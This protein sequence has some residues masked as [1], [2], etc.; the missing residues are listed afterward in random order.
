MFLGIIA[1]KSIANITTLDYIKGF[2]DSPIPS[3]EVGPERTR[4]IIRFI[5]NLLLQAGSSEVTAKLKILRDME[6]LNDFIANLR[7]MEK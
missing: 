5:N 2:N 3:F 6:G 1:R 4:R 7:S